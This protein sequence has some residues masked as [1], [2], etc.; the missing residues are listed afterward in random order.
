MY[1]HIFIA[2][3]SLM[4]ILRIQMSNSS[5]RQYGKEQMMEP[6]ELKAWRERNKLTQQGAAEALGISRRTLV[7]YEQGESEIPRAFEYACNWLDA[8]PAAIEPR[9]SLRLAL[10]DGGTAGTREVALAS[11]ALMQ[12]TLVRLKEGGTLSSEMLLDICNGAIDQHNLSPA[13]D[14]PWTKSV[15][16]LIR[17]IFYDLSPEKRSKRHRT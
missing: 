10:T 8:N 7:S 6:Q 15:I 13:G 5:A 9:D 16:N 14:Q 17:D 1:S 11:L 4:P 2:R 12:A 3:F